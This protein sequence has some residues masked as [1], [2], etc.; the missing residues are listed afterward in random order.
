MYG[1]ATRA[2]IS[3]LSDSRLIRET[4]AA[5]LEL[6]HE[7]DRVVT[8]GSVQQL[9]QR[10][11]GRTAGVLLAH[12]RVDGVLARELRYD[13]RTLL[14][15]TCLVV[16]ESGQGDRDL[17]RWI[18]AGATAYVE[19]DT[20]VTD[21]LKTVLDIARGCPCATSRYT[22][23]VGPRGQMAC[24][25]AL[26]RGL[27]TAVPLDDRELAAAVLFSGGMPQKQIGSPR[28][29]MANFSTVP[30]QQASS[31]SDCDALEI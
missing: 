8:A 17:V 1:P 21:L 10:L 29:A 19:H 5:W 18:D 9:R 6:Q 12:A 24:K 14:P 4:I 3:I 28:R 16:I 11:A 27:A 2:S 13:V 30:F 26:V 31:V 7:I 20:S 22:R 25:S 23:V 15:A